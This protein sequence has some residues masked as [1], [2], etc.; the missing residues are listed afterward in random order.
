MTCLLTLSLHGDF[1]AT[2]PSGL[3]VDGLSARGQVLLACLA[4]RP[5]QR[6]GRDMLADL[7]WGDR[8][9]EQARASLRQELSQL[10][11]L[12]PQG[13]L[14]ADRASVWLEPGTVQIA[15]APPGGVFLDGVALRGAALE[16]WLRDARADDAAAR[17]AAHLAAAEKAMAADP[18]HALAEAE[19]AQ[20]LAADDERALRRAMR[21]EAALGRRTAAL[22]R[23]A[24]FAERLKAELDTTPEAATLDLAESL[25]GTAP[26]PRRRGTT[27]VLAVLPFDDL[28]AEAGDMFADGVVEEITGALSRVAEFDVIA[29][30]SAFALRGKGLDIPGAAAAL[31]ADYVVE[32]SVRRAGERVRISVQLVAG[33][34]GH[35][36]WSQ[37]FDDR[38][39]DLFD[40]QDRIAERVAGQLSP[41]LRQAEIARAGGT[42]PGNRSAYDLYLSAFPE[43]WSH[44]GRGNARAIALLDQALAV[45]PGFGPALAYKAWALAQQPA[46]LWSDDPL[47]DRAAAADLAQ[48]AAERTSDH[49]P[50]LVATGAAI[51][52]VGAGL[53]RATRYVERALEIDPNNSWG[54]MRAGWNLIY[55]GR[56]PEAGAA[57]HHAETLSPLDPFRFNM[58]IGR[59]VVAREIHDLDTALTLLDEAMSLAPGMTW[60]N[61]LVASFAAEA[62]RMELARAAAAK[63]LHRHPGL[64]VAQLQ[65]SV[66]PTLVEGVSNYRYR[67]GLIDAGIPPG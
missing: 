61:R 27:P 51:A 8:G 55:A 57:F 15:D 58:K 47:A 3:P 49:A 18:A 1:A 40:L 35:M 43:F 31:G 13:T 32:G 30:Q 65:A 20:A 11:K 25:K 4:T 22:A 33:S 48:R 62:G 14:G 24:R 2:G 59:A 54:H 53:G 12:L 29:R 44:T 36:L 41:S 17:V 64:T 6:A 60:A 63:L 5:E 7:L 39:D 19:A 45:D 26:A 9:E 37:R 46:Y 42:A 56:F 34:D 66:P 16:D 50:S 10:R 67:Q 21:A 38:L 52:L 28:S 23:L